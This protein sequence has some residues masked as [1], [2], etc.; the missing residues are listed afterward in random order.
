MTRPKRQPPKDD[1]NPPPKRV[2]PRGKGGGSIGN[3]DDNKRGRDKEGRG[4]EHKAK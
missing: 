1:E 2:T 4:P 3:T